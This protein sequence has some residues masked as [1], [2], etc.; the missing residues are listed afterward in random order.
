MLNIFIFFILTLTNVI[1]STIKSIM[2]VKGT[3]LQ[4][5][6]INAFYYGFYTVVLKQMISFDMAIT[7]SITF[8][9]NLIGVYLSFIILDR[10]KKDKLWTI[11]V[12]TSN[13]TE[14]NLIIE[15]LNNNDIAFRVY[16]IQKKQNTTFGIDIFSENQQQSKIIENILS[17]YKV[18]YHIIETMKNF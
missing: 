13:K 8:I 16:E 9:S 17:N 6:L 14:G 4:A 5:T 1:T 11:S 2:T 3:R 12:T 7:I 18:K 15:K 10:F